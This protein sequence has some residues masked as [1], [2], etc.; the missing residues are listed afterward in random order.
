MVAAA[1]GSAGTTA[2]IALWHHAGVAIARRKQ[3]IEWEGTHG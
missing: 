3:E 2:D 1:A